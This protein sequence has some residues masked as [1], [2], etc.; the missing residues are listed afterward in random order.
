MRSGCGH[1]RN[2]GRSPSI[3]AGIVSPTGGSIGVSTPDDHFTA[4][5]NCRG[6]DSAF[7]HVVVGV[8]V[9]SVHVSAISGSVKVT[10]PNVLVT[11]IA[12]S[13]LVCG[14]STRRV[15]P[16]AEKSVIETQPTRRCERYDHR[17]CFSFSS[18]SPSTEFAPQILRKV[19]L[20]RLRPPSP[21]LRIV[22][23][24]VQRYLRAQLSEPLR[25]VRRWCLCSLQSANDNLISEFTRGHSSVGRAPAL[26]AGS[27]G[28][29]S[30]C[31]HFNSQ[32]V[33]S[34]C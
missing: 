29:E 31:L 22:Q 4:G 34:V 5:P 6:T 18:P 28:F 25:R 27:Q 7:G 17:F 24:S 30:P 23:I 19:K 16:C 3:R 26:Q 13:S 9:L 8:H 1:V 21:T 33:L 32:S 12:R 20:I 11:D 10:C 2:A 15:W 14:N